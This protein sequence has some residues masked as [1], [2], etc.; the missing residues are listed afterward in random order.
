MW[1]LLGWHHVESHLSTKGHL[2]PTYTSRPQQVNLPHLMLTCLFFEVLGF[3]PKQRW[4][5]LQPRVSH[6]GS[7]PH[8]PWIDHLKENQP[9]GG[10]ACCEC[11]FWTFLGWIISGD[12]LLPA[13]FQE[14]QLKVSETLG[15][16]LCR[17]AH[18]SHRDST[19]G[20]SARYLPLACF[21]VL[22]MGTPVCQS[23][24]RLGPFKV[25]VRYYLWGSKFS[26][27]WGSE[28]TWRQLLSMKVVFVVILFFNATSSV[29]QNLIYSAVRRLRQETLRLEAIMAYMEKTQFQKKKLQIEYCNFRL[30]SA[31][32]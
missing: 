14:K 2:W 17:F 18:S 27:K 22:P 19:A 1:V 23:L 21:H 13:S 12:E 10:K 9:D 5:I 28:K 11:S 24:S 3:V 8:P 20:V 26:V 15:E 30:W 7:L 16:G 6:W 31:N 32:E 4:H 25:W 29:Y